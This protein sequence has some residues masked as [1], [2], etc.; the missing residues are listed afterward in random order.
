MSAKRVQARI[1]VTEDELGHW[2]TM[3]EFE[4]GYDSG[5]T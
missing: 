5:S 2:D 4:G 1:I 3:F